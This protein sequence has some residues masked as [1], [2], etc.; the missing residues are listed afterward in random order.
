MAPAGYG[1]CFLG[2]E[3]CLGE[4]EG[5]LSGLAIYFLQKSRFFSYRGEYATPGR[6]LYVGMPPPVL[7]VPFG[8][9]GV[10]TRVRPGTVH[11]SVQ[12][13]DFFLTQP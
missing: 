8:Q 11:V 13:F 7:A 1:E 4:Q 12:I 2:L 3:S 5:P 9:P 6:L 10:A